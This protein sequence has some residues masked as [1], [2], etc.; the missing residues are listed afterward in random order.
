MKIRSDIEK[1]TRKTEIQEKQ[2][3]QL[4]QLVILSFH[5]QYKV[6]YIEKR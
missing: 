6:V 1:N 2:D 3:A 4:R 5:I